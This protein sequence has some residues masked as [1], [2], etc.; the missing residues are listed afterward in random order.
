MQSSTYT[1]SRLIDLD[2]KDAV[3]LKV[4]DLVTKSK[5]QLLALDRLVNVDTRE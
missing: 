3:L 1:Q 2:D 4:D 5:S